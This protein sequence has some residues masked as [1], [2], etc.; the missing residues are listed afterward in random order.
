MN[1]SSHSPDHGHSASG[2]FTAGQVVGGE[3][4]MLKKLLGHG[5]MGVVWLAYDK[6]LQEPVALKFLPP[7]IGFDPAALEDLRRETLRARKLSHPNIIRI[8]DLHAEAGEIPFVSMEYVDGPNLHHL[9]ALKPGRVLTWKV[10]APLLRQ[11][12]AALE[13][14]HSEKV[15]HRDL[16]PANL[17]L[18][19]SG[20]LKLADFGLARVVQDSMTRLTGKTGGGTINFMSPQQADGRPP[21]VTDDIYSLGA[22]LYDLLTSTPPFYTGDIAYQV[23]HVRPDDLRQRLLDLELENKIPSEVSALVMACLAK[24]P[25]QRPQTVASILAWLEAEEKNPGQSAASL[26]V[27]APSIMVPAETQIES[28]VPSEWPE[29]WAPS[30]PPPA[31]AALPPPPAPVQ[32]Q[33]PVAA[34]SLPQPAMPPGASPQVGPQS[35]PAAP[36]SSHRLQYVFA[37]V[38]ASLLLLLLLTWGGWW[39]F[40]HSPAPTA[41]VPTATNNTAAQA[42]HPVVQAPVTPPPALPP[43]GFVPLFNGRD[44]SGWSGDASAWSVRDGVLIGRYPPM[45]YGFFTDS[46]L[47]YRWEKVGDFELRFS[48]RLPAGGGKVYYRATERSNHFAT[49]YGY[50]LWPSFAGGMHEHR[51]D[52]KHSLCLAEPNNS[53]TLKPGEWHEGRILARSNQFHHELDRLV[54]RDG[55]DRDQKIASGWLALGISP[56]S[57]IHFKDIWLKSLPPE[58]PIPAPP[59]NSSGEEQ[60]FNGRDLTGWEG[61]PRWWKVT[62]GC[63]E[64]R[65]TNWISGH[66]LLTAL[67]YRGAPVTNFDLSISY[68]TFGGG[69]DVIYRAQEHTNYDATGYA[70]ML[71][72]G[73]A[74]NRYYGGSSGG[75]SVPGKT[76]P[77]PK[78]IS[79][80]ISPSPVQ[81]EW[82]DV[83]IV[84]RGN[85]SWHEFNGKRAAEVSDERPDRIAS[86]AVALAMHFWSC[87]KP[88]GIQVRSI[89]L[90]RLPS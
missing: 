9:R 16:K 22:T 15:V 19:S 5:G 30:P 81:E 52:G 11:L 21:Q 49:G 24:E 29:S 57:E 58:S 77:M 76:S 33:S 2:G 71:T 83:T 3:R 60:L 89:R 4:Y 82:N 62:N 55:S 54:K 12:C 85:H 31:P 74:V 8:H 80:S 35:F 73:G 36:A 20:R 86:G 23:R 51:E 56:N 47:F 32:G 41:S 63:I 70:C 84:V 87:T 66:Q 42:P 69:F 45:G 27:P 65:F 64:G 7:Q 68:R 75:L 90:K 40:K 25:E 59:T 18:D 78:L 13:Y 10:L 79:D 44:L 48:F 38:A 6:R 46:G 67:F 50:L 39:W 1:A 34:P 37:A 28:D 53:F 43:E 17:M 14:A 72:G 88:H 26:V 61:D